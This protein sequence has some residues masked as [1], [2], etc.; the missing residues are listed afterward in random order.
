MNLWQRKNKE[1]AFLTSSCQRNQVGVGVMQ[2]YNP[3]CLP[4][5]F[6]QQI[7]ME[8]KTGLHPVEP[9]PDLIAALFCHV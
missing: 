9:W 5:K 7:V 3:L 8:D 4:P 2:V 1:F 6:L